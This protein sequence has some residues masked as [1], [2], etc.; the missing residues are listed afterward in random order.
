ML[1]FLYFETQLHTAENNRKVT[2]KKSILK[3]T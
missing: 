1:L 3:K 2:P